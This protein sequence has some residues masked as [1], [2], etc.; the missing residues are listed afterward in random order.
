MLD[1]AALYRGLEVALKVQGL[2]RPAALPP[3][4]HA[5]QISRQNHPLA[6]ET[7]ALTETYLDVRFGHGTL[8]E[9]AKRDFERRVRLIR[10]F[11]PPAPPA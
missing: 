5:E 3:L 2:A 6:A 10:G 9:T 1:A 11:R 7:L 8:T 4:R